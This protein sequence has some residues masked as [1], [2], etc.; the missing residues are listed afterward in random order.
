MVR[1]KAVIF[2]TKRIE[3][4]FEASSM[5]EAKQ[6]VRQNKE[7]AGEI[8]RELPIEKEARITSDAD[9]VH[10]VFLA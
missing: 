1:Y 3:L 9:R 2:E 6:N 8:I 7:N 4:E 10:V 5:E